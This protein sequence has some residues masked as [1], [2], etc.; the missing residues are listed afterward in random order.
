MQGQGTIFLGGPPLVKAATGEEVTAEQLGGAEVHTRT[1]GVAD[2]LATNDAHALGLARRIVANLNTRKQISLEIQPTREPAYDPAEIYGLVP[3]DLRK[4]YDSRELLARI[5]DA[6]EFD[7]FKALYGTT[8]VC[9]FGGSTAIRLAL[10]PT[11]A[12]FSRN[13]R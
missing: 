8:L 11:T 6:S 10:S 1:S 13:R 7:E 9:G 4:P 12:F 2:H 5:F 3:A